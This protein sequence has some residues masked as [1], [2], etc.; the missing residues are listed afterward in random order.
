VITGTVRSNPPPAIPHQFWNSLAAIDGKGDIV[1]TFDKFHL[2]PFGEYVPFRGILPISK[3]TPG[4][5]DFTPGPG[6][7]TLHLEG[8]PPVEPLICYEVIFPHAIVD[9][10]DRPRWL[11]NIT[12]DAWYGDTSGPFQPFDIARVRA[13]EEG[14]PLVRAANNGISGIVD[15][16]GRVRAHL[17]LDAVGVLDSP[18]PTALS[19]PTPY[20]RFGDWFFFGLAFLFVL[21][22]VARVFT[23]R[24]KSR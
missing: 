10:A 15:A 2:V 21:A 23:F 7:R 9:E 8:L 16:Y 3:I 17:A 1:A 13:V 5:V 22:N 14:L 12:N 19:G 11:L 6:P 20:A 24:A 18:L 4:T